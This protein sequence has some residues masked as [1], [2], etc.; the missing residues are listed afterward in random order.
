MKEEI[1]WLFL[2]D[3]FFNFLVFERVVWIVVLVFVFYS[4]KMWEDLLGRYCCM[5]RGIFFVVS[6]LI[7]ILRGFDF[8]F[9]GIRMGVFILEFVISLDNFCLW[10]YF[11]KNEYI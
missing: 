2:N 3:E 8:F 5:M 6:F 1:F 4:L 9:M 7:V 10:D 11:M